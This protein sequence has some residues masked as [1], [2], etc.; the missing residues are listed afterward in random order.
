M[1]PWLSS[2]QPCENFYRMLRSMSTT[3]STVVN[4]CVLEALYKIRRIELQLGINNKILDNERIIFP[5]T[6]I[7]ESSCDKLNGNRL[8]KEDNIETPSLNKIKIIRS[9]IKISLNAFVFVQF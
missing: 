4:C 5:K 1:V 8:C 3:F 7:F 6:S 2:S 9:I